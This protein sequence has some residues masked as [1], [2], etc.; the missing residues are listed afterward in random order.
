MMGGKRLPYDAEVEYLKSTGT[1]WIDTG[2]IITS[3]MNA[4]LRFSFS[5]K[6]SGDS[7]AFGSRNGSTWGLG[8]FAGGSLMRTR[9]GGSSS[10]DLSYGLGDIFQLNS[11]NGTTTIT[12]ETKGAS[13]N[14]TSSGSFVEFAT[15]IFAE[16][17]GGTANVSH[18]VRFYQFKVD[19]YCDFIPVRKGTVGYLYDRV[20][21]KLF[22]NAGTGAFLIGPDVSAARGG[23]KRKCVRRSYRRSSR[24]SA[25]FWQPR[26]WKEAA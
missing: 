9:W 14:I 7:Y 20:S 18:G 10:K 15:Y 6:V 16:N 24:P 5:R 12:N 19:G 17:N 8:S 25:R 4:H 22:G 2:V 21:G 1:Q 3:A 13:K 26:L 23:Y 11:V